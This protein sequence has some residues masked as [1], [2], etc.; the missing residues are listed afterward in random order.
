MSRGFLLT[1]MYGRAC[2]P[3]STS[4]QPS[5]GFRSSV[6]VSIAGPPENGLIMIP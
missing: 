6:A 1:S 3:M 2:D 4:C 5:P